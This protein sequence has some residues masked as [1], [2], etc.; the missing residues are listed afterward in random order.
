MLPANEAVL[1]ARFPLVHDRIA[2]AGNRA[3]ESCYYEDNGKG[4]RLFVRRG[5]HTF[6]VYG[7]KNPGKLI[8][9]WF[10]CLSLVPESLYAATGFGDGSHLRKF[11]SNTPP[12][13]TLLAAE[14]DPAILR[15]TLARFD[16][17]DL[18]SSERLLLGVG[19]L[20]DDFFRDIE[21]VAL[22]GVQIVDRV[23]F[24]PLYSLDESY[25]DHLRNELIR[26]YLVIRP[27]MEVNIR[28]A[29]NIQENTF[30]NLRHLA[31]AP[32]IGELGGRFAEVPFILVGAGPSLDESIDF[33]REARDKAIIA[34]SN[35][36]YRKLINSGILPHLAVTA[37]PLSPTLEGFE[38]VSLEG[39]PLAA[40][41]SAY[42]EIIRRFAGRIITWSTL[43]PIV[44]ALRSR[45]GKKPGTPI[46]EKGT[47]S[48]C[49]LDL[50]RV[51]GC[52]QV[53][54]VGQDLC[55]RHDGKYYSEDS[56]YGDRGAHY[57]QT[58]RIQSLPGNTLDTVPVESR[59][60]V[61]LKTFEEYVGQNPGTQYRNLAALG[62]RV[63]GVPYQT[64]DEAMEWIEKGDSSVFE[65]ALTT[66]L[67]QPQDPLDLSQ[68]FA[69]TRDYVE[70]VFEGALSAALRIETL[71][72]KFAGLNYAKNPKI[73]KMQGLAGEI[74]RLVDSSEQDWSILFEG[75]T[76]GELV[77]Y[78]RM[79]KDISYPN[80]AW[81]NL[82]R[83]KEYYWALAEG[84]NWLIPLMD[85]YFPSQ[86]DNPK[87]AA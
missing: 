76:K 55:I 25:Y 67:E 74:N 28:T 44:N 57:N 53:L 64:F 37:D 75:R 63:K 41:F 81:T 71:P 15:E 39:V 87:T 77:N 9:R 22:T 83:N 17:S 30:E 29:I 42:P 50:A 36:S 48:A 65:E 1:K 40:P 66:L 35:S 54:F 73:Q 13:T 38:N 3:P 86:A 61:Y 24:S 33:L 58:D 26:Q 85:K 5:E 84:C 20:N 82:T 23:A 14:K 18:L 79:I 19:E 2:Q 31:D 34:C 51:L 72:A 16:L 59:L 46:L 21:G 7:E 27:L 80:E 43:N 49:V 60:F 62:A 47:V 11:L 32:D 69:P 52:K 78:R 70:K 8:E 45:A 68:I 6:P 12:G 56:A 10:S 4:G